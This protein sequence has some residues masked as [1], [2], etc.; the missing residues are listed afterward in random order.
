MDV[1]AEENE[2]RKEGILKILRDIVTCFKL[3]D[4]RLKIC[5]HGD[6]FFYNMYEDLDYMEYTIAR[7]NISKHQYAE[8]I[9][10]R[11]SLI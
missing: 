4:G 1:Y 11:L 8:K 3:K 5:K 7:S 9:L 2:P 10:T 6:T